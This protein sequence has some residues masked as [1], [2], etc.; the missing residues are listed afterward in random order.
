MLA[1]RQ[2]ATLHALALGTVVMADAGGPAYVQ[3]C[4]FAVMLTVVYCRSAALFAPALDIL[5]VADAAMPEPPHTLHYVISPLIFLL[6]CHSK[7][8]G[9]FLPIPSYSSN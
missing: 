3:L 5:W 7:S 6:E 1:Y 4:P 9:T 2:S 8:Y